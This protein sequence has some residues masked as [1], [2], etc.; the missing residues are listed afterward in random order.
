[1]YKSIAITLLICLAGLFALA[2]DASAQTTAFTYQG[3]LKDGANQATGNYDFEFALFD[4]VSGGVQLGTTQTQNSVAVVNGIFSVKLDFGS[5]FPGANRF[6]EIRL[7]LTGQPGITT[8]APRQ[9]V[10]SAPYSV[11]SL[12][13]DN[14]AQ[15]GGVAA[16][17][18]V[19]TDDPRMSDARNPLPNS[20]NYIQNQNAVPQAS[21]NF[22]IT[23]DGTAGG[24]LSGNV[25][26]AAT[27]YNIGGSRVLSNPGDDNLFAGTNAGQSNTT[28]FENSFFGRNAGQSNTTGFSNSF[29]G[30]NAGFANT[31]GNDN[32]FFGSEAGSAN[33]G[34]DNSFFGRS[35]GLSNT[36]GSDNSF[37]ALSAA[38]LAEA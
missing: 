24:T 1:M 11:K 23:G 15:L 2:Q 8:L 38:R 17:Q 29:V 14:A 35:A 30:L 33:K 10:T 3:S 25:V 21:G 19:L 7:R 20:T 12:N 5:Q 27:K 26:N 18:Y 22:N 34:S 13:T 6:L 28:G 31:T 37:F 36:T 9:L 16:S 4:A 32:S